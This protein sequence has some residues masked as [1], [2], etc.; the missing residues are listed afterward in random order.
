MKKIAYLAVALALCACSGNKQQMPA[1]SNDYAVE[2]VQ[3]SDANLNTSYPATIKGIQDIEIRP[4]IAGHITQVLVDE[5]QFVHAGQ[6]L[7]LIDRVQYEAIVKSAKAS[8]S[9]M[10]ANISTQQLTVDNK[11]QLLD[12][13]IIS[14]YDY[15]VALNQLE[16]YKAQLA[17]AQAALVEAQ[18]NLNYCTITSP[19]DGVVG[20]IPYRVGSLV[21]SSQAEALTTVS[22]ISNVYVYFSM[23][24]KQMLEFTKGNGGITT[25]VNDMPA[26]TLQLADGTQYSET[27]KVTAISGV[28]DQ[29]TGA[30]QVRATFPNAGRV[31]RSGGTGSILMPTSV[32]GAILVPQKATVEIQDKKFVY[33]LGKE[34]KISQREIKVLTQND[35]TNYVVTSG[36]NSGERIVIDGVNQLQ[37]GQTINPI[38]PA[39]AEKAKAKAKADLEAGKL[40]NEE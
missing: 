37:D 32:K 33:V 2:T 10:K 5:G 8:I 18:N 17:Q 21:S 27:G 19:A 4:K 24:E 12:K 38:T 26:V 35:G 1:A 29:T 23:T 39:Q 36:L 16:S 20:S 14:S 15:E 7:F 40:P 28:I 9:V 22:N 6:P 25:A 31:L 11:K 30:V 34:N 3:A 13:K